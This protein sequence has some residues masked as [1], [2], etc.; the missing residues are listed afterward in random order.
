VQLMVQGHLEA[1]VQGIPT[2]R[3]CQHRPWLPQLLPEAP[4]AAARWVAARCVAVLLS[5]VQCMGGMGAL[6]MG[7]HW[8]GVKLGVAVV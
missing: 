6:Y 7:A 8:W 5:G 1:P 3:S 2:C 4:C